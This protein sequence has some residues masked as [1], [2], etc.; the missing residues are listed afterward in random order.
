[1]IMNIIVWIIFGA[2]VGWIASL[3]MRT[4]AEQG[5]VA[6]IIIGIIGAF[7]GGAI[8]RMFGAETATG[9]FS[10]ASLIVAIL[11]ACLL[12]FFIRMVSGSRSN[13]MTR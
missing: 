10:L 6:N 9:A 7:L 3:I 4:D 13:T 5:A 1:M 2:L 11:G 8:A 12:I